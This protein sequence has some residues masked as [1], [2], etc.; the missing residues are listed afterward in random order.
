MGDIPAHEI[1]ALADALANF[2]S[3][4]K[5]QESDT[6]MTLILA[7]LVERQEVKKPCRNCG[8]PLLDYSFMRITA[9]GRYFLAAAALA[10]GEPK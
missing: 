6:M 3:N 9:A 5:P 8:Q 7:G 4:G 1:Q 2:P 10:P